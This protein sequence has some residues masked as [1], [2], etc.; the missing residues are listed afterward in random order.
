MSAESNI[1]A[2]LESL[3]GEKIPLG[4]KCLLGRAKDC[5]LVIHSEKASRSHA[6]IYQQGEHKFWL[7]D[8][9]SANGTRLKGRHVGQ[10]WRLS[11]GD[12]I[13]MRQHRIHFSTA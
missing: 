6:I 7:S 9:R 13:E 4:E 12:R 1:D 3:A 2:W 11:D 8:L 5:Q 10:H